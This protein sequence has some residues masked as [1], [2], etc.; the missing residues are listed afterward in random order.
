MIQRRIGLPPFLGLNGSGYWGLVV[1]HSAFP[2]L[3]HY[4][5]YTAKN[6]ERQI[7]CD[8]HWKGNHNHPCSHDQFLKISIV[9]GTLITEDFQINLSTNVKQSKHVLALLTSSPFRALVEMYTFC[10]SLCDMTVT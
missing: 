2:K 6:D 3:S 8:G 7:P 9:K 5:V 10:L 1:N 4:S